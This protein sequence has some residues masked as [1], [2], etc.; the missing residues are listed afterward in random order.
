DGDQALVLLSG[1]LD[2]LQLQTCD[3]SD[4][5]ARLQESLPLEQASL[6]QPNQETKR[7][8]RCLC[9]KAKS[10]NRLD[11]VEK[12]REIA[13]AGT[14]GPLLSEAL[15]VRN[16]PFRQ[17]RDLTID[18]CG[19]DEWKPFAERLGLTPAEI[20]Y[21][22]KRV[23]NPCDAALAHSRNQGYI[24]SVGDLYD[25]LVDCELPLIADLL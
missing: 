5:V 23:L 2:A 6:E 7:R 21:L 19:G 1:A 17:R 22:D 9:M 14:T 8:I 3:P 10:S 4:V 25:T 15:D 11:V 13:P 20:R 18:L 12:L 16:I 24:S